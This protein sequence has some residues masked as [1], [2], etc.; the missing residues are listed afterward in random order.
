MGTTTT[1]TR[2]QA[3]NHRTLEEKECSVFH[4]LYFPFPPPLL[5]PRYHAMVRTRAF[6]DS[7]RTN[8]DR[9]TVAQLSLAKLS[10]LCWV[11]QPYISPTYLIL[12]WEG[13]ERGRGY[14]YPW[15]QLNTTTFLSQLSAVGNHHRGASLSA[16]RTNGLDGLDHI[17]ALSHLYMTCTAYTTSPVVRTI[18]TK[19]IEG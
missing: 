14:L 12:F 19:N 13:C 18:K 9:E 11:R 17:H 5:S 1:C 10:L 6:S 2:K 3:S 7:S 15:G 8:I 16:G 4:S